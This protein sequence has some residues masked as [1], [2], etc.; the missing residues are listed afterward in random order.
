MYTVPLLETRLYHDIGY[1]LLSFLSL[2]SW[3]LMASKAVGGTRRQYVVIS[4]FPIEISKWCGT[5]YCEGSP[6]LL[7]RSDSNCHLR[8]REPTGQHYY[9]LL[10]NWLHYLH[11]WP[12]EQCSDEVSM[13]DHE[14]LII[15]AY[16]T[17]TNFE[18][19]QN[20]GYLKV[21]IKPII[22]KLHQLYILITSNRIL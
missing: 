3:D 7:M 13:S 4:Y 2:C 17:N 19:K 16:P 12:T 10:L 8:E 1:W 5:K 18:H 11:H 6:L 21:I 22:G 14:F 15:N 9:I 20:Y